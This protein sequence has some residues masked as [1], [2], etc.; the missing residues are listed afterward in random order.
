MSTTAPNP[1]PPAF[2]PAVGLL[3]QLPQLRIETSDTL[4]HVRLARP[5]KRNAINDALVQ[6][7]HTAFVN[8]PAEARAVVLSGEGQ[9]F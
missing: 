9:Q 2:Q 7:L 6:Q 3:G 1:S 5:A 4:V 8:L